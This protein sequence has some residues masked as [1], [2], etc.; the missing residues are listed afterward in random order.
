MVRTPGQRQSCWWCDDTRPAAF[1]TAK[2]L[3]VS[4]PT[5]T[6]MPAGGGDTRP[7]AVM[8]VV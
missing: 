4:S 5:T 7:A 2:P 3:L 8:L 1:G 6:V